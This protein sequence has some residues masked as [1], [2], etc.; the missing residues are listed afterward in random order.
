M[1]G[2]S[3]T[4]GRVSAIKLALMA[5]TAREQAGRALAAD[6][7]AIVGMG[8]RVPG[9]ADT[10]DSF[11]SFLLEERNVAQPVPPA[12]WDAARWHA[13]GTEFP[14]RSIAA[15]AAFLD[16][17]DGFDADY[18]GIPARE[19]DQM[20]PQQRLFLEVATEAIEDAGLRFEE[21]RRTRTGVFVASYHNDYAQM[22]Y[23]D[24]AAMDQRTLTG[25]LHSVLANRLSYLF[26]LRGPSISF[27][28]ACSASLVAI[29]QAC[30]S[31][32][33][34]ESDL[35]L[36]G[37]VSLM[38]SPE[39]MVS[40]SQMGF[41][42]P[43]GCCK[44]FDA[45]A[46]GF[47][48]G[49]GAG[50]VTLKRL[51]DALADRDRIWAVI[52]GSAVNQD[53]QS[54]LLAAPNGQA[55]AALVREAVAASQIAVEDLTY[56]ETHGTGTAL[57]DPIEVG[58]LADAIGAAAPDRPDCILGAVKANIGHLEAAAGVIGVIKA[59]LV[60]AHRTVPAQP[61][62][63]RL[64]PH[65][66]LSGTRLKIADVKRP[67]P[68]TMGAPAAG[69]SS[70]GVGGTNAHVVLEAAPAQ[71]G[72]A[73]EASD[74]DVWT[75]PIS[76]RSQ[77]ALEA[78]ARNWTQV[79]EAAGPPL[80]DLCFTAATRRSHHPHRLA[81]TGT[82]REELAGRLAQR[83]DQGLIT[84]PRGKL[85][86]VFCGQGPQHPGMGLD[87]AEREPVFARHLDRCDAAIRSIAGWSLLEELAR[88]DALHRTS[89]AQPAL[90]ALQTGLA[91][92]LSGWGFAADT[93]IG[94]SIG[95]VAA[96][97]AAGVLSLEEALRIACHRG[98]IMQAAEGTGGMAS[99]QIDASTAEDLVANNDLA[100]NIAAVN[101]PHECV[102]S[103]ASDALDEALTAL[104]AQGVSHRR[105]PVRYAF[106]SNQMAGFD[107]QLISALGRI[108]I[109]GPAR[110]QVLSTV[111]GGEVG[112]PDAAHFARGIRSTVRFADAVL[113][114][115][116]DTAT[117][118][119]E[120]G[121]H[122]VLGASIAACLEEA[123]DSAGTIVPTLR[124]Q[125]PAGAQMAEAAARLF[126]SGRTPDWPAL[127]PAGGSV[128]SLPRYPWQHRRH[129]RQVRDFDAVHAGRETGHP[130]LGTRLDI[131]AKDF[132]VFAGG[133]SDRT[134]W[135]ADHRIFGRILLPATAAMELLAAALRELGHPEDRLV[136]FAMLAP[137][138]IP[139]A[140]DGALRWQVI[141]H[142][143][144]GEWRMRLVVPADSPDVAERVIAEARSAPGEAVA[145]AET[146][147]FASA[148]DATDTTDPVSDARIDDRFREAGAEF[149]PAFRLLQDVRTRPG[150]ATGQVRLSDE[151]AM[152]AHLLHP[153]AIDAGVQLAILAAGNARAGAWLPV[154]AQAVCLPAAD[155]PLAGLSAT[156]T[157]R[158]QGDGEPLIADVVFTAR[159]G[160][161]V[162]HIGALRFAEADPRSLE[163]ATAQPPQICGT[164]WRELAAPQG[165]GAVPA[166]WLVIATA[167]EGDAV[168]G[169]LSD[170]GATARRVDADGPQ[171]AFVDALDWLGSAQGPCQIL[172]L[173][174]TDDRADPES[175]V[176][177]ALGRL[178]AI[179]SRPA[180][181]L[182]LAVVTRGAFA[183]GEERGAIRTSCA[184]AA[185]QAF[186]STAS[187]EHPELAIRCIDLDPS[188]KSTATTLAADV[189]GF[190]A[191]SGPSRIALRGAARLAPVLE[192]L[193]MT[194]PPGP[195]ALV[196]TPGGG[197]DG[198][199]LSAI[200]PAVLSQGE[201]RVAVRAAGLNFRD[202]I[203]TMGMLSGDLPPLGVE[204]AGE[205]IET[206]GDVGELR[207][208]DRV[209]GYAPGA[210]A[211]EVTV[212]ASLLKR[213]PEAISDQTAAGLT[214]IFGTALFGMDHLAGLKPGERVL[215]HAGTGGVGQAA[216]QIAL[217]R[218]AEVFATAG[219][220][221]KRA[222]L[223]KM[224]VSRAM[225]SRSTTFESEIAE[226]TNGA[227]VDVV[228]NSLA[229][230]F[231]PASVRALSGT[232]R[233]LELG[234]RDLLSPEAFA[235]L[236]PGA[237]YHV[238]DLG[239]IV[240]REPGLMS[241]LLDD[242]LS[243]LEDGRLQPVPTQ[244]FGL[245]RVGEA[246]RFMA[247]ARHVGKIVVRVPPRPPAEMRPDA[248]YWVTGGF[249]GLGLCTARWLAEKGARHILLTG[250]S[251]P[252]P[253]VQDAIAGIEALGAKVYSVR[254]D[255]GVL[256]D[257]ERVLREI[258]T[259]MP[260]L[261]GIVHTAGAL[262]DGPVS[263][264]T[265]E[266]VTA[267][268]RG[269]LAGALALDRLTRDLPL[270]FFILYSAAATVLGSP[271]QTLYVAANAGLD[272]L[273]DARHLEGLPALSI[274][275]GRWS[276]AGMAARLADAGNDIW[277]RRG[278]GA[279]TPETGFA[280]IE[281]L[282]AA[283]TSSAVVA[284]V[285]WAKVAETAPKGFDL[286][287]LAS[288]SGPSGSL[289][290][291][292]ARRGHDLRDRLAG[293]APDEAAASLGRAISEA[294]IKVI[295]LAHGADIDPGRPMKELG[296]DSL[297]A[298]ELR[299]TLARQTA[300]DLSAT[301][302]FD[303]PT[304]AQLTE[305]LG[306][307]LEI[308]AALSGGESERPDDTED[309]SEADLEA[310][311]EAELVLSDQ[312]RGERQ[313]GHS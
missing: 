285:D 226:A 43:D 133:T 146:G 147:S 125:K 256:A 34:G 255:A 47:G 134:E 297:M 215:I 220:D 105:L 157:V 253:E 78:A 295:G 174:G 228:L 176:A 38:M 247:E 111:T 107:T 230:E 69:V 39:L 197:I 141:A 99:V 195:R 177:A 206:A 83:I 16:G 25:T 286:A 76:A 245:E 196:P 262:R 127:L 71:T 154:G 33:T 261:R 74:G 85:C 234:K 143:R 116:K 45:S 121:P 233:F 30:Q 77:A 56:V 73:A 242:I 284:S 84:P 145:R 91:E 98:R 120:I 182:R 306:H 238:Y 37:G 257:T 232:G 259:T 237:S 8:C 44:T 114:A 249:G 311:L 216:I 277:Q 250:R 181:S 293:L 9:G 88:P 282:L 109:E 26:D 139:E 217:A 41:L 235:E 49:E 93:V 23:R 264:R 160:T 178:Q 153:A 165:E 82:S 21:L 122:P 301:L 65:I 191:W 55:Q 209:F 300:L 68:H 81:V 288:L 32:R 156:A 64:N 225:D 289:R 198:L 307:R 97:Q 222:L 46:N 96:F 163:Q 185:L 223:R 110:A 22:L 302:L 54:T 61:N 173:S 104:E 184:G 36:A 189:S 161:V 211:E 204:M 115:A 270:D 31:L 221:E 128:T 130:L 24:P 132:V 207:P 290:P 291:A 273:A 108:A 252:D 309:L 276:G 166:S 11:W 17:I 193:T 203:S 72:T 236:R 213:T 57:G 278:L 117:V 135:L 20:D 58:A 129:W 159:D 123:G 28:T 113:G 194:V 164:V 304:V 190:I 10:P 103:G 53:G 118:F 12:R 67:L 95:E 188:G 272:A 126:E 243:G 187:T 6:P 231:I 162:G 79:L 180:A 308:G 275:W 294:A 202:V 138:P 303:Y 137:L 100:L 142:E 266:D 101:G 50:V 218:G 214:V 265:P 260:P 192:P 40:M 310:L 60:L 239:Q 106:H 279:I 86:L 212:K 168:V 158:A 296:L 131:S 27:D 210:L 124:R 183:T 292:Q 263:N 287:P 179:L 80:A 267:V 136:D 271:G 1:S 208:G 4:S 246:M 240:E 94:H 169:A 112:R 87:L 140:G 186:F 283:G 35:V 244:C 13:D 280:P 200:A 281:A 269:K 205:V 5:R 170:L 229:G 102:L 62:F 268:M 149:G 171:K 251:A 42:A 7:I 48:R 298:V 51:S 254:A 70:F 148:P 29:H 92:L 14:G 2:K 59:A 15:A 151:L 258:R 144:D 201:V 119:V 175:A 199:K 248:T 19:A 52:R 305:Y 219:T 172:D 90:A 3:E 89:V 299:N 155:T 312:I 274:A 152:Q 63:H 18:F 66:D 241:N 75:L 167:E 150:V 313:G 227:G 224:G